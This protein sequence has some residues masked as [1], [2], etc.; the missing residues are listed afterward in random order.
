MNMTNM[1]NYL[2]PRAYPSA[3]QHLKIR[4]GQY[5]SSKLI[6]HLIKS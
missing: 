3:N 5:A 1:T 2:N 4:E 6:Q